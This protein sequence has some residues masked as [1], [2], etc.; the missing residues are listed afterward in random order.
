VQKI[1][2][3][4]NCQFH[5]PELAVSICRGGREAGE[6]SLGG[7]IAFNRIQGFIRKVIRDDCT[8]HYGNAYRNKKAGTYI[9]D[10]KA[11]LNCH[12]R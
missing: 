4:K 8:P 3:E 11:V 9:F 5:F 6:R 7:M 12:R 1:V 10:P 2:G